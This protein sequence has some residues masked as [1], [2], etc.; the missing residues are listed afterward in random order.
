MRDGAQFIRHLL[1]QLKT[2]SAGASCLGARILALLSN[3]SEIHVQ[4]HKHLT[5]TVMEFT[6]NAAAF[7]ILH[8]QQPPGHSAQTL[9]YAHLL[10]EISVE[11]EEAEGLSVP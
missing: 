4:S 9:F 1:N 11:L 3:G 2:L 8:L 7:F 5:S 6:G 10:G